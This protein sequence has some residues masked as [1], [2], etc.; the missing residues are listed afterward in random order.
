MEERFDET[1]S[2]TSEQL[3]LSTP[4]EV[5]NEICLL[6]QQIEQLCLLLANCHIKH[7]DV[8]VLPRQ[9]VDDEGNDS[10]YDPVSS[11]VLERLTDKAA[12][13]HYLQTLG[14]QK[15]HE[16]PSTV[17]TKGGLS[18]IGARRTVG[19]I[20]LTPLTYERREQITLL[21]GDIN[22]RKRAIGKSLSNIYPN[23]MQRTRLFYRKYFPDV[24]PKSITRLLPIAEPH[25]CRVHFSWLASGYTQKKL[26]KDEVL[27]LVEARCSKQIKQD[28]TL[29]FDECMRMDTQKIGNYPYYY[30]ISAGKINPRYRTT[31]QEGQGRVQR[32][33]VRAVIPILI[34]QDEAL[35]KYTRLSDLES[36]EQLQANRN[37]KRVQRTPLI[38]ALNLYSPS[39]NPS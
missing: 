28:P 7:C 2:I 37:R 33:P 16:D 10:V 32:P 20:H 19:I 21:V 29:N 12:L 36:L 26:N 3:T 23:A 9:F 4:D 31:V 15:R 25:T 1:N 18:Q 17:T 11:I 24:V 6:K 34:L 30:Q 8:A 13:S 39:E 27:T 38:P 14:F 5:F 35:L 22:T